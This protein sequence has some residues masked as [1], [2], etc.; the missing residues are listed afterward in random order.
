[1]KTT[2]L[3]KNSTKCVYTFGVTLILDVELNDVIDKASRR[4]DVISAIPVTHLETTKQISK[5]TNKQ[6]TKTNKRAIKQTSKQII[7]GYESEI[8]LA[9]SNYFLEII[10]NL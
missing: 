3:T 7:S 4:D 1:M 2:K 8:I 5:S 10:Y 9:Q 6:T